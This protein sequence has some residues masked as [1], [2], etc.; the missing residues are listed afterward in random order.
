MGHMI[1]KTHQGS[2]LQPNTSQLALMKTY[3]ETTNIKNLTQKIKQ[4]IKKLN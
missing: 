4:N 1:K 3:F 2:Y